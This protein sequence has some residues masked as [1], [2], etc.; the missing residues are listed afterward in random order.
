VAEPQD[1][2]WSQGYAIRVKT[3][4]KDCADVE[5]EADKA[6]ARLYVRRKMMDT[7]LEHERDS[8]SPGRLYQILDSPRRKDKV[9]QPMLKIPALPL[10]FFSQGFA[11]ISSGHL[12]AAGSDMK[13]LSPFRS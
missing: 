11:H 2:Q 7:V 3:Q 5:R 13:P 4:E 12:L 9:G 10:D 6:A 1:P 8:S